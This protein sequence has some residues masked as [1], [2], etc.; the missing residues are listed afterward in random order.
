MTLCGQVPTH[1]NV[2]TYIKAFN[3]LYLKVLTDV[4][5]AEMYKRNSGNMLT[6]I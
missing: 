2:I 1:D 6:S 4:Q 5:P 3:F